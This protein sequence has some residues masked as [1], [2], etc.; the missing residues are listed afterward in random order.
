MGTLIADAIVSLHL[1]TMSRLGIFYDLLARESEILHLHFWDAAFE[2]LK[3]ADAII[4]ADRAG[5]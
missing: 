4:F 3:A 5:R 1:R 2:Q